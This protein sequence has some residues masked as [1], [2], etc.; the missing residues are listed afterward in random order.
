MHIKAF[1]F[2]ASLSTITLVS[3]LPT[4]QKFA[5]AAF[6]PRIGVAV[7]PGAQV[8][9]A[10]STQSTP[11]TDVGMVANPN[12]GQDVYN[13]QGVKIWNTGWG[14]GPMITANTPEADRPAYVGSPSNPVSQLQPLQPSKPAPITSGGPL[15]AAAAAT[16]AEAKDAAA[17]AIAAQNTSGGSQV[18]AATGAASTPGSSP[19]P[20]GTHPTPQISS[21]PP[22]SKK[23]PKPNTSAHQPGH[24][25]TYNWNDDHHDQVKHV[26]HHEHY[27]EHW[28]V[29]A[30]GKSQGA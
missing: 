18:N 23:A 3:A 24:H 10:Q 1:L 19:P 15:F 26:V 16:V 22:P 5:A 8:A 14:H 6:Q 28:K 7:T 27:H 11:S 4:P 12:Q 20:A 2:T 29:P 25:G 21:A 13:S 30:N 9:T 17:N